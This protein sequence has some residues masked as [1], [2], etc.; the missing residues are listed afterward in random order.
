MNDGLMSPMETAMGYRPL[1]RQVRDKIVAWLTA[2]MWVPG[3]ALPSET[4]LARRLGVSQ[5]TV[6]KA[7]DALAAENVL[8]RRQGLGTFVAKHGEGRFLF[9][10]FKLVPDDDVRLFPQSRV[11]QVTRALASPEVRE[12]LK[13]GKKAEAIHIQRVRWLEGEPSIVEDIFVSASL[14]PGLESRAI[15]NNL[16]GCYSDE[17]FVTIGGGTEKLKAVGLPPAI[18][19]LLNAPPGTP[20]LQV[21]R[22]ALSL[23]GLPVEWRISLCLTNGMHYLSDLR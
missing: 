23:E 21:D 2:G 4:E 14:F 19:P 12:R 20:A 13:L 15:P 1:Y 6:R 7:L 8:V 9:Q 5:G 11:V 18:A 17:Y 22:V 10:F 3:A 16:Y